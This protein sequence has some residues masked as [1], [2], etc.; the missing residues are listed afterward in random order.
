MEKTKQI[1]ISP[2]QQ[3]LGEININTYP[4]IV[5]IW[6]KEFLTWW[7][8]QMPI[9]HLRTLKRLILVIDD[10]LTISLLIQNFFLPWHRD[11][12]IIGYVFGIMIK[13]IYLPIAISILLLGLLLYIT[14]I[15]LWLVI[16]PGSI[17]FLLIT[18][19]Q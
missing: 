5:G 14:F 13:L 9:W 2:D 8:I 4:Q 15:L 18:I 11:K 1:K 7:Y 3:S 16:P 12:Q 19:W 10:N 6:F 17:Y